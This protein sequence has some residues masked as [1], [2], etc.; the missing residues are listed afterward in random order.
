MIPRRGLL[1]L[2]ALVSLD[3]FADP[4][5]LAL[6]CDVA[7]ERMQTARTSDMV[8]SVAP[9]VAHLAS[10]CTLEPGDLIFTGTPAGI[11]SVRQPRRY[12]KA[13]E[14]IVSTIDGIG[15][16]RNRCVERRT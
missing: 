8:F 6:S 1:A 14:E 7:G 2:A 9:L 10:H 5:D 15:T 13:G 16:L 11:G 12:L 4:N 3:A